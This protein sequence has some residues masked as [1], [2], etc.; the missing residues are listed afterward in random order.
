MKRHIKQNHKQK[1]GQYFTASANTLLKD[2][3]FVV[4]D[5]HVIDPF[6]GAGHLTDWAISCGAASISKYDIEPITADTIKNDSILMPPCFTN[7]V[8]ITNP[9]YLSRNKSKNKTLYE[10]W[11]QDD[12]YKCHLA[13]LCESDLQEGIIIIP[14]NFLCEARAKARNLFFEHFK[15]IKVKYFQE[16]IFEDATTGV[17]IMHFKRGSGTSQF[18]IIY[19][20][21]G[22]TEN[23]SLE[24]KY[25]WI[26]GK[27]F[28]DYIVSKR[29]MKI[30]N[31]VLG[32]NKTSNSNIVISLLDG[33]K[34][35]LCAYYNE[36]VPHRTAPKAFTTYQIYFEDET[37]LSEEQERKIVTLYNKKLNEFR[38][39]YHSMFLSNY[40]G[41]TQK[42]K[43]RSYSY[44]LL[45]RCIQEI[46]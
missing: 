36:G 22:D 11:N 24:K 35:G 28:F 41:A 29:T 27:D 42:I 3:A 30:N 6:A 15:I 26:H 46:V 17:I 40:M 19:Y 4:K 32:D 37:R 10:A 8:L 12:L 14:S 16:Q 43:S 2:F 23:V 21:N 5:K 20:P 34:R 18:E 44:K 39:Q 7:K 31:I 45:E 25:K 1:N 9:P 33:S 13:A 38:K